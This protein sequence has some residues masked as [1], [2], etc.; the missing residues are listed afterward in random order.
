MISS[1]HNPNPN[2]QVAAAGARRESRGCR[3][4]QLQRL[5]DLGRVKIELQEGDHQEAG[6]HRGQLRDRLELLL[7]LLL[8]PYR[9][10][11]EGY[12]H[13]TPLADQKHSSLTHQGSA[14]V[15]PY[16]I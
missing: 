7:A 11:S 2:Y 16:C 1:N 15:K 4:G 8:N 6:H 3:I 13:A 5:R 12:S 10:L 9:V 14:D